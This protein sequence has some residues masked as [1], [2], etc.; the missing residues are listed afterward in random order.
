VND[1]KHLEQL[2]RGLNAADEEYA[3]ACVL[4]DG[5]VLH[6]HKLHLKV[7]VVERCWNFTETENIMHA[8]ELWAAVGGLTAYQQHALKMMELGADDSQ[9]ADAISELEHHHL[10]ISAFRRRVEA[11]KRKIRQAL[12]EDELDLEPIAADVHH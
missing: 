2:W 3:T 9:A 5:R 7:E 6:N 4:D 10:T 1:L 11:I 12:E 8:V